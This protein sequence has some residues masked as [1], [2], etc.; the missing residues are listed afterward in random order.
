MADISVSRLEVTEVEWLES[1][2]NARWPWPRKDGFVAALIDS[3]AHFVARDGS[4]IYLGHCHVRQAHYAPFV[5]RGIPEIADLN[6]MPDSRR[7]GAA[8][9]MLDAVEAHIA[10]TSTEVGI[11][12]GI[13]DDYGPAQRLYT[14]RGY[15]LDGTGAWAGTT[16]V[17]GGD[18]VTADDYLVLYLTKRLR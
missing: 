17:R 11:G 10:L 12:V 16:P 1:A 2:F 18:V 4:G 6:V 5:E 13:Y 14:S 7:R 8:T 3:C 9:A 15:I